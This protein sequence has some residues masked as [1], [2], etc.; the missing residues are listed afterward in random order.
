MNYFVKFKD[1]EWQFFMDYCAAWQKII[2]IAYEA[3]KLLPAP[4]YAINW[5]K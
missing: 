2:Y 5:K 4:Q 1:P 3:M